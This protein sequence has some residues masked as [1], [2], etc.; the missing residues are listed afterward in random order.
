MANLSLSNKE[1]VNEI[2]NTWFCN[3]VNVVVYKNPDF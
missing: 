1:G 3:T 2:L